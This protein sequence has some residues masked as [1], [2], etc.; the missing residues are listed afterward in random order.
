MD[1]I[2]T[3]ART[4]GA[5]GFFRGWTANTLK[6]RGRATTAGV[7]LPTHMHAHASTRVGTAAC[8]RC[9]SSALVCI[10]RSACVWMRRQQV[11]PM[12]AI[13]FVSY[14]VFKG[15]LNVKRAS[16]DT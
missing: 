6:A 8:V 16:S 12:S 4:E 10:S 13:R 2:V 14:E 7:L 9:A 5:A 15:L 3:I 11:A 1:A